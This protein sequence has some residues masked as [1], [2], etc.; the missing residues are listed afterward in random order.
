ML[1]KVLETL[2]KVIEG[3]IIV[4]KNIF[5]HLFSEVRTAKKSGSIPELDKTKWGL[6]IFL[7][8]LGLFP[9][10]AIFCRVIASTYQIFTFK[11][12][13]NG[14]LNFQYFPAEKSARNG[15]IALK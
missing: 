8:C 4:I 11:K 14:C 2:L 3:Q 15:F 5:S 12:Y 1:K 7:F 6:T 13:R 9:L 10:L